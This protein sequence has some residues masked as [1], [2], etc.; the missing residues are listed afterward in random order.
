VAVSDY[1]PTAPA[2]PGP[3][4]FTIA[5]HHVPKVA[6]I[7]GVVLVAG[8]FYLRSRQ[9][10]AAAA[11][12]GSSA[13]TP[14]ASGLVYDPTTGTYYDPTS[15]YNGTNGALGQLES[16]LASLQGQVT[17][18]QS[19]G[20]AAATPPVAT[21]PAPPAATDPATAYIQSLYTGV[22]GRP[23]DPGGLAYW[24]GQTATEG[25]ALATSQFLAAPES[26]AAEVAG[27]Y[28]ADLSRAPDPGGAAYWEHY[29]AQGHTVAQLQSQIQASPEYA[30]LHPAAA[31][32][33]HS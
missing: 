1:T 13:A 15:G 20:V 2:T 19:P 11:A 14:A 32:A 23:P 25:T 27:V 31:V 26:L 3:G 8:V 29:L 5:G 4:G 30:S 17:Q 28:N 12:A 33:V 10:A 18:L 6:V 22:L 24:T 21:S 16:D 7:G 9:T